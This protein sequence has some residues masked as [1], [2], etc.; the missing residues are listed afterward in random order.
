MQHTAAYQ[1][2]I[3]SVDLVKVCLRHRVCLVDHCSKCK[4]QFPALARRVKPG[5]CPRCDNW[6]GGI[7]DELAADKLFKASELVWQE[8]VCD[9]V[10]ELISITPTLSCTPSKDCIAK[11]LQICADRVTQGKMQRLSALIG[12]HNLTVHEWW[13]GRIKPVLFNLLRI[14]YCL[15]LRLVDLLTGTGIEGKKSFKSKQFP[16]EL[17]PV[18]RPRRNKTFNFSKVEKQLANY[19][20][21]VQIKVAC[22]QPLEMRQRA[23]SR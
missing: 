23:Q 9:N 19:M 2:L 14:C 21:T 7:A 18:K 22:N 12:K 15:D 16:Q 8:F 20:K 1:P 11:W 4:R 17:E 10:G 3:W 6:L 5:F 13:L